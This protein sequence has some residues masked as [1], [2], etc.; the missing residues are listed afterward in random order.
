MIRVNSRS[1]VAFSRLVP[2][3]HLDQL[4]SY[5]DFIVS[6]ILSSFAILAIS[7]LLLRKPTMMTLLAI[8]LVLF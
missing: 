6:K 7:S 4:P 3:I 8:S 5:D 2:T 1:V